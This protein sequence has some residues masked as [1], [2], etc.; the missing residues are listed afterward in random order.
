M[1]D[2]KKRFEFD[3][4]FNYSKNLCYRIYFCQIQ[5]GES[6]IGIQTTEYSTVFGREFCQI[7]TVV[8][9]LGK[10]EFTNFSTL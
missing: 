9:I 10:F 7:Y 3:R 5:T 6:A 4:I 2:L 1:A 8:Q